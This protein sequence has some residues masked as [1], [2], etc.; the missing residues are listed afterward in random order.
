M[1][2]ASRK[3]RLRAEKIVEKVGD[4][5]ELSPRGYRGRNQAGR[6]M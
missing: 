1:L 5:H 2:A 3:S 6:G 4:V